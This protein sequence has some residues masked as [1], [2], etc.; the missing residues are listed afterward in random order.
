MK[1]KLFPKE[2]LSAWILCGLMLLLALLSYPWLPEQ[3]P[4]HFN[5]AGKV[6]GTGPRVMIFLMPGLTALLLLL[7]EVAPHID[8]RQAN[9]RR[10]RRQYRQLH[11]IA[12]LLLLLMELYTVAVCF[13]P[14]LVETVS[15]GTWMP[16]LIGALIAFCGN[17]MPKLKHNYFAGIKTPWTLADENVWYLT[18]RFSGK[19]YVVCGV[20]LMCAAFLPPLWKIV[21]LFTLILC[22]VAAPALYSYLV[23]RR[24]RKDSPE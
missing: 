15:L 22:M 2:S 24:S 1:V 7:A 10:F 23:F 16:V 5:A 14:E 17:I 11:F 6:D 21:A 13:R 18:H 4:M 9:Y 3:I 20:L 19:L 12:A 8:P